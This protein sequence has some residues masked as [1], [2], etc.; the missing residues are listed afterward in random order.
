MDNFYLKSIIKN[1]NDW[2]NLTVIL[3]NNIQRYRVVEILMKNLLKLKILDKR[4]RFGSFACAFKIPLANNKKHFIWNDVADYNWL[5]E[6]VC[7]LWKWEQFKS[8]Q[9][10]D[11]RLY[12]IV[13]PSTGCLLTVS[14]PNLRLGIPKQQGSDHPAYINPSLL[15]LFPRAH[16]VDWCQ[17]LLQES[18]RRKI[19]DS[20][21]SR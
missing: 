3:G 10:I 17:P 8:S 7:G 5:N 21:R 11:A 2:Y 14:F 16:F 15:S 19:G 9:Q 13:K 1:Y 12:P 18:S 4:G 6:T 20:L